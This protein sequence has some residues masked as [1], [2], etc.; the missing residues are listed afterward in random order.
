ME[1]TPHQEAVADFVFERFGPIEGM[2]DLAGPRPESI[3]LKLMYLPATEEKPFQLLATSGMCA[4][5]MDIPEE[6]DGDEVPPPRRIELLMGLPPDWPVTAATG[7][8][9]WPL[10]LMSH[11]ARLPSEATGWLGEGH[12]IPNGD[13]MITYAP[14]T[15]FCCA[16]I[17]PPLLLPTEEQVIELPEG[18]AARLLAVVPLFEKE[19]DTKL[20]DGADALFDRLDAHKVNEVLMPGRRAVSGDLIDLLDGRR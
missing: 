16:L 3:P 12:T 17:A 9:M 18:Q 8:Q 19:V 7:E 1:L 15:Q 6:L 5:P 2:F 20:K 11:L 13:P 4:Q 14:S 10:R